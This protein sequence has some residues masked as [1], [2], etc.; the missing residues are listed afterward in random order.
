MHTN[1]GKGNKSDLNRKCLGLFNY[2][3]SRKINTR[4]LRKMGKLFNFSFKII[5]INATTTVDGSD[6]IIEPLDEDEE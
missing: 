1:S 2:D 6:G 4:H 5:W 3:L